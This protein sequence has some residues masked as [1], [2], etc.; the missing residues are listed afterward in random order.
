MTQARIDRRRLLNAT[1]AL[2]A[3]A[4]ALLLAAPLATQAQPPPPNTQPTGG[5]VVAGQAS[6]G[7]T[8][9]ATTITQSS[10]R[11]AVNWQ[12]YDVGANQTVTYQQPSASAVT[13]N[14]VVGPNPSVVAGTIQANGQ[15]VVTNQAGVVFTK[16]SQ[17]NAAGLV[18]SAAGISTANFMAGN[19]VFDQ[20]AN[21]GAKVS[22]HGTITVNNEGLAVLVAPQVRNAGVIRAKM[23][24][25]ILAGAEAE[26][27]DL[28]GDGLVS[29]NVTKQV[30]SASDGTK[31]LVTNTGTIAAQGGSVVLTADAVDGVVQTLVEAGG[32]ISAD[33]VGRRTGKVIIAGHGGDV[34][35]EGEVN[36]K[37]YASGT[38]GGAVMVSGSDATILAPTAKISVS[39]KAGGGTVALGTT[40]A[41]AKGAGTGPSA[42]TT[43]GV[44]VSPGATITA[45]ATVQ[46]NGGRVVLLSSQDTVMAGSITARGAGSGGN[47]GYVE[48][49]GANGFSYLGGVD[50]SAPAG[51]VGTLL[52][53]P[54]T[55]EV[56]HASS[57]TGS[58]DSTAQNNANNN[59]T[60]ISFLDNSPP[61]TISDYQINLIG[62]TAN[63]TLQALS[64][65]TVDGTAAMSGAAVVSLPNHTLT[66]QTGPSGTIDIQPGAQ[67]TATTLSLSGGAMSLAGALTGTTA[68]LLSAQD[69]ITQT[70]T[71][72]QSATGSITTPLL[73]GSTGAAASLTGSNAVAGLGPFTA[74]AGFTLNDNAPALTVSNVINGGPSVTLSNT[75]SLTLAN[76]VEATGTVSL[77]ANGISQ[78]AAGYISA[79][80]LTGT[81][82]TGA[83]NLGTASNLVAN[84]GPFTATAGF[85]LNDGVAPLTVIGAVNGGTGVALTNSAALAIDAPVTATGTVALD[86]VGIAQTAGGV[87]TAGTLTGSA[88]SGAAGFGTATNAVTGLGPFTA[89]AGFTLTDATPSLTV[90]GAVSGG[91]GVA[92]SNTGSLALQAPVTGPATVTLTANG[93][94]QTAGGVITATTL[95]GSGGSGA[96]DLGSATNQVADLGPFT[97]ATGFTFNDGTAPLTVTGA[98][99][100][101]TGVALTDAGPLI[102]GAPVTA[103][104]TV[105]LTG[106]GISQTAAGVVTAGLLTGSAGGGTADFSIASNLVAGLGPFT[107]QTGF[108]LTDAMPLLTVAGAVNG[109]LSVNLTNSGALAIDAP[110][111]AANTVTLTANGISQTAAGVITATTLTGTAGTGAASLGAATSQVAELGPFTATSGFAFSDGV[112]PL[113]VTGAINGG[114]GVAITNTA[115]LAIDAPLTAT[116]TVAL[117]AVGITQTTAGVITGATLSGSAGAGA[118][119][120][121]TATNVVTDLGPFSAGT[122]FAFNDGVSSLTIGGAVNGGTT[123]ALTNSG[124]LTIAAPVTATGTVALNAVGITQT[125]GGVI[126]AGTLSGSAGSGAASLGAATNQVA[127]LGPFTAA[128]GFT[129]NDGAAPLTVIGAVNGGSGVAL[130]DSGALAINAPVTATGTVA[131]NAVGI[132]QT[133][134]GVLTAGTLSGSAG[135]GAADFATAANL[136]TNLGPFTAGTGFALN[137]AVGTLTVVGTVNGGPTV[138]LV[139]TGALALDA[140]LGASGTVTLNAVGIS[141]NAAGGIYAGTLTGNAGSGAAD[142]ATT[143]SYVANLGPFTA[144]GAFQFL[145][146]EG[147]TVIADVTAGGA[148]GIAVTGAGNGLT[149]PGG[150][151]VK[152]G[153]GG[154]VTL[155]TTGGTLDQA[156]NISAGTSAILL[157]STGNLTDSGSITAPNIQLAAPMGTVAFSGS[158]AGVQ[159]DPTLVPQHVL[160]PGT[161]PSNPSIGAW[162]SGSTITIAPSAVVAGAGGGASELVVVLTTPNGAV[163]LGNINNRQ[164]DLYLNLGTGIAAGQIAVGALQVEYTQPGTTQTIDLLGTVNGNTGFNAATASFIQPQQ[165]ANYQVNGCPIESANCFQIPTLVVSPF[166]INPFKDLDVQTP[167]EAE[168]I[169]I[170]LPDVGERDY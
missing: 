38:A 118:A 66:L 125:A 31:A 124:A 166:E 40:L 81:A 140:G 27:L 165:K 11:A 94:S 63:V 151:T 147:L 157:A 106:T 85:T 24:K 91:G 97:A 53:D 50:L 72:A 107:A 18:V 141:Q 129:L 23:G 90:T 110:V 55:L 52:L 153:T 168:D 135:T 126:T 13:L 15:I 82:G 7:Q 84:L 45:D 87:I 80:T 36:A 163:N 134:A 103:T 108:T 51:T 120:L 99:N 30:T 42:A 83:A 69:G 128:T 154:S 164:M 169:L 93:I 68:V 130:A 104:G 117:N 115:A 138:Y 54:N 75:G 41:R 158:F 59:T 102:L 64:H 144:G 136:V 2:Q 116:G 6:I 34:E 48:I 159:P 162:I 37:G 155:S 33:S 74:P 170:I 21:P 17:V 60:T 114:A 119:A 5:Q 132:T 96:A 142:L 131:L 8:A 22:N 105:A 4:T 67:L 39:G 76:I 79:N 73:A 58:L 1:T 127:D 65:L 88:G 26:T 49:S 77:S 150:V 86:A 100:G 137:D 62:Q 29:I 44:L 61:N 149:L 12:S 19:M 152:S 98:V 3:A 47:G 89:G 109:G 145:D 92:L 121:A 160:A 133:A 28:Y 78:T 9:T 112:A 113:T 161:F 111:T 70:E 56:I 57:A 43:K 123:V 10:Q 35:V 95:T 32:H 25:V 16:G 71:N 167:A 14:R 20:A 122:G 148:A 101:G 146:G 143:T 46:G 156:G 139:N